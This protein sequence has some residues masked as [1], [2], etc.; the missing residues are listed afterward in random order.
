MFRATIIR[1]SE[2]AKP[3]VSLL[4]AEMSSRQ[5]GVYTMVAEILHP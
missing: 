4:I 5:K 3:S 2:F 1:P